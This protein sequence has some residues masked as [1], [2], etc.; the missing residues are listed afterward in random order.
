VRHEPVHLLRLNVPI[1]EQLRIEEALLRA[2]LTRNWCIINRAPVLKSSTTGLPSGAIILG[3]SGKVQ[4]LCHVR[5]VIEDGVQLIRRFSGGG[6]VFVDHD[7]SF[8]TFICNASARPNV[9]SFP[10]PIMDWS[11]QFYSGVFPVAT[12]FQLLQNDYCFGTRKFGGNA[13]AITRQRWAHHTSFL[14]QYSPANLLRYL[15]MPDRVPEYRQ[16]RDHDSFVTN[17]ADHYNGADRAVFEDAVVSQLSRWFTAVHIVQY[18]HDIAPILEREHDTRTVVISH[19]SVLAEALLD[20]THA[21][22]GIPAA[23][24][25]TATAVGEI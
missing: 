15:Q 18:P 1:L 21:T 14:W 16:G 24:V 3:I 11:G 25:A 4:R 12:Q 19:E 13:Q 17:M 8:V 2:D 20:P 9:A 10:K 7:T 23:S 22:T 6:T 5:N